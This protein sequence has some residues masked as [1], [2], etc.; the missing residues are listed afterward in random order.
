MKLQYS[1]NVLVDSVLVRSFDSLAVPEQ[2][3]CNCISFYCLRKVPVCYWS[4]N[5][6]N[7]SGV[8]PTYHGNISYVIL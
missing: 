1:K 3:L 7:S 4:A 2:T 8:K 6:Y 5:E